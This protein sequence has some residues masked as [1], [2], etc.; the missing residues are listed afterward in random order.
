MVGL[1][2]TF[3]LCA[4]ILAAIMPRIVTA[5]NGGEKL[6]PRRLNIMIGN[7]D[8]YA[9]T[10]VSLQAPSHPVGISHKDHAKIASILSTT[11]EMISTANSL[12]DNEKTSQE[13]TEMM[14]EA[15]AMFREVTDHL[16]QR[17]LA[18]DTDMVRRKY[19][20]HDIQQAQEDE[21]RAFDV[22]RSV[23]EVAITF[24]ECL[25]MFLQDCLDTINNQ[26]SAVG[27]ATFE[28]IVHEKRNIDQP[29]YNKVVIITNSMA[30]RVMGRA[31]D[32][33]V[34]YPFLWEDSNGWK[35][36]GVDGKWNCATK[37][38]EECCQDIKD[39]A[40]TPDMKGNYIECHI[41]VPFGGKDKPKRNDRVF[42]N[43]S[44]DGRVHEAPVIQ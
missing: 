17:M 5:R 22:A 31:G 25:E 8:E 43:V 3:S 32:G 10:R 15:N 7:S 14:K 23:F 24:P 44:P 18:G 12:I 28:V 40:P 2:S 29:G 30:D 34:T 20:E 6:E 39:S 36:L 42:V 26:A 33:I 19:S 35:S 4:A 27:V 16:A 11:K 13:G 38:P 21:E 9:E 41:F 1:R 37:T